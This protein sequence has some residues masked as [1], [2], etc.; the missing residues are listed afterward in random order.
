MKQR[1]VAI[2]RMKERLMQ[3]RKGFITQRAKCNV[4]PLRHH[5]LKSISVCL[6]AAQ[7]MHMCVRVCS[8]VMI[9]SQS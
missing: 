4:S 5:S 6:M 8:L 7:H 1:L 3:N 9:C 2:W